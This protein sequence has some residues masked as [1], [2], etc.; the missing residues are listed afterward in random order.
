VFARPNR[1]VVA[2]QCARPLPAAR[3]SA[4]GST[5]RTNHEEPAHL[6]SPSQAAL[7]QAPA[8]RLD[9]LLKVIPATEREL[10]DSVDFG[11][12]RS[13]RRICPLRART[14][15]RPRRL[16][17]LPSIAA[18]ARRTGSFGLVCRRRAVSRRQLRRG[19]LDR[20]CMNLAVFVRC[21]DPIFSRCCSYSSLSSAPNNLPL[22]AASPGRGP[23]CHPALPP[24]QEALPSPDEARN[25]D[26]ARNATAVFQAQSLEYVFNPCPSIRP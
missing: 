16:C 2:A 9:A 15:N 21:A 14:A 6:R 12:S 8:V 3:N 19:V 7:F 24:A 10:V 11:D 4:A 20:S 23:L 1:R 13:R 25:R 22:A 26:R 17:S 5:S 18:R